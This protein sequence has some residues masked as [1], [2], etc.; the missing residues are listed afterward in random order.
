MFIFKR[1]LS[2]IFIISIT[3]THSAMADLNVIRDYGGN[4]MGIYYDMLDPQDEYSKQ[5]QQFLAPEN[6]KIDEG[7]YLPVHSEKL[8][9]GRFESYQVDY[10]TLN[11]FIILGADDLSIEWL[12]ARNNDLEA[13]DGLVG[14]AVN[15]NDVNQLKMLKSITKIPIYA[16]PGDELAEKFQLTL[17]PALVTAT[18]VEQ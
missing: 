9:V 16:M 7:T 8:S 5:Q 14:V 3:T 11:P 13:I 1:A 12:K 6:M 15:I 4:S 18:S 10:P 2:L 17:Y